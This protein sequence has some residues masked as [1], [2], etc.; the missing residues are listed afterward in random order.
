MIELINVRLGPLHDLTLTLPLGRLYGLFGPTGSGKTLLLRCLAGLEPPEAGTVVIGGRQ[1]YVDDAADDAH[2]AGIGMVFDT[3]ATLPDQT[4]IENVR[5]PLDLRGVGVDEGD[6]RALVLL[7]ELGIEEAAT[8]KPGELSGGMLTRLQL[9]RALVHDPTFLLLDG[10]TAGLDP[11]T[12]ARS[13]RMI[14]ALLRRHHA[15][16]IVS[17]QDIRSALPHIDAVVLLSGG[18]AR[19][20]LPPVLAGDVLDF[21]EGHRPW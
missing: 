21:C 3:H 19:G 2:R 20:P 16:G 4:V 10:P 1:L 9:A 14:N 17:T 6:E 8:K 11:V 5:L 7:A 12:A 15:S 18:L 13:M